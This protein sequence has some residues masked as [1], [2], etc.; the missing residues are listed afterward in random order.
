M[1]VSGGAGTVGGLTA[2]TLMVCSPT[3]IVDRRRGA[4]NALALLEVH[5]GQADLSGR[6]GGVEAAVHVVAQ[7]QRADGPVHV[8]QLGV[9][10]RERRDKNLTGDDAGVDAGL[11]APTGAAVRPELAAG[12]IVIA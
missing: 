2:V 4:V 7:G 12:G 6:I 3:S 5:A 9:A 11:L 10:V 8:H 1:P